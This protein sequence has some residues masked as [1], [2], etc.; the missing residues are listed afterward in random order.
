MSPNPIRIGYRLTGYFWKEFL[1]TALPEERGAAPIKRKQYLYLIAGLLVSVVCLIYA[2]YGIEFSELIDAFAQANYL[3]LPIMWFFLFLFFL[4]KGIRW[5]WLLTPIGDYPL[6]KVVPPMMI[7]FMGNNIYPAHLGDFIRVYVFS[8]RNNV[9][10]VAILSGIIFERVLDLIALLGL[11]GCALFFLPDVDENVRKASL[12]FAAGTVIGLSFL[13]LYVFFTVPFLKFCRKLLFLAPVSIQDKILNQLEL[14]ASGFNVLRNPKL[15]IILLL[16]SFLQWACNATT[17]YIALWGFGVDVSPLAACLV[18]GV[19]A[20][21]VMIPSSPGFFGVIQLCFMVSLVPL[22]VAK[23]DA[24]AAS[25][26][27]HICQYV[28][29]TIAGF[30]YMFK[31]GL[32]MKDLEN[33]ADVET[34]T[35]TET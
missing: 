3:S 33:A 9:P 2:L 34:E 6:S 27:Y 21:G 24:V 7:G 12:L 15:L 16:N 23:S 30:Y 22:G 11:T 25:F 5:K 20:F 18:L 4:L 28:P 14:A 32:H 10:Y 8:K 31:V 26:Y 13:Y 17:I 29:V 19:T 1:F 35:G